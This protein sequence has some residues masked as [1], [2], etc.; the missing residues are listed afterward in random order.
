MSPSWVERGGFYPGPP[1][2]LPGPAGIP[3]D[4]LLTLKLPG[5]VTDPHPR[6]PYLQ[7]K[8]AR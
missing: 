3:A 8:I 4:L 6:D 1:L 5:G 2:R 7:E